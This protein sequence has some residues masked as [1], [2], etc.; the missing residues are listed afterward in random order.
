MRIYW[1]AWH[2]FA[3]RVRS[4][5]VQVLHL[6]TPG[7]MGLAAVWA[8]RQTG[9]PLIGSFHTDIEAYTATLSGSPRLA[10]W[11]RRYTKWLYS[12]CRHVLVPSEDTRRMLT[13]HG[14]R[15]E[16]VR[17]WPRGVDTELFR[18]ERRSEELRRSWRVSD[19][20]PAL[21]YVGRLSREKGLM[22]L[23]ALS[24]HLH[25]R[26]FDHRL[27]FVGDGPIRR[28]LAEACPD[29]VFMGV[30]GREAVAEAFASSDIFVFPSTTDTAGN[31][32]LEAQASGLP[33]VVSA[34]GGPKENLLPDRTGLVCGTDTAEWAAALSMLLME[35]R[36]RQRMA[37]AARGYSLRRQWDAALEPLYDTYRAAARRTG[38]APGA[39]TRSPPAS[40]RRNR[41]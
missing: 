30:R 24:A 18:P 1:P 27:V 2:R 36:V 37:A 26:G 9:L 39:S 4:D 28:E 11:M 3:D 32:V 29:A 38:G 40:T 6:T 20:R 22:R 23:P 34:C 19:E 17:V 25:T 10:H 8:A 7:P 31:V 21:L 12:H 13:R 35:P 14:A 15:P 41:W 16:Q 33:V 5:G